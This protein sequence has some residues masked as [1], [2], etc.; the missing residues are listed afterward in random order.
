MSLLQRTLL[1]LLLTS[2]TG[3][4]DLVAQPIDDDARARLRDGLEKLEAQIEALP[5]SQPDQLQQVTDVEVFAKAVDWIDRHDEFFKPEFEKHAF[6]VLRQGQQRAAALKQGQ[7][8]WGSGSGRFILGY[9][10]AVDDSVQPYAI[11]LPKGFRPRATRP[12]PLHV[13]LHGRGGTLNEVSFIRQHEGKEVPDGQDWIQLDVFGRTN[14]A[15]RWAGETDV[16]EAMAD[17]QRRFRIDDRRI[18]LWGFSMGGAGAW[19]LGLHYPSLW[20][21]VGAGAGFVDFYRYQKKSEQLPEVQHRALRICDAVDYALN[22]HNVPFIT[23]GGEVDPQLAA[24][25]TMQ[26]L[27]KPL[28]APLEVLIGAKMGHKFD[29]ESKKKFMAFHAQHTKTGRPEAPGRREIRFVTLTPKYNRCEWL[30]LHEMEQMYEPATVESS[31]ENGV[32]KVTTTNVAALS[33]AR[34]IAAVVQLD[35]SSAIPLRSAGDSRLPEVSFVKAEDGWRALEGDALRAFVEN[36][37]RHKRKDLQ[38]PI[39]DAFMSPFVCVRGTGTPWSEPL[40]NWSDWTFERFEKEFDKWMRGR[41][42]TVNDTELTEEQIAER[43]LILFGDPGSNAILAKV[44]GELPV[45]WTRD[46]LTVGGQTYSTSDHAVVLIFPNPLN[47]ERYVVVNSGHTIHEKDFRSSNAWL[48]PRLG[49][50]SVL[51]FS[52]SGEGYN[53]EV[54]WSALF[55]SKW[56]LSEGK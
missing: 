32:L 16:L 1:I 39:D 49:D 27:A 44:V 38:G 48:F 26:E 18:T 36:R 45:E 21:S 54:A 56:R 42:P 23:Y 9:R 35:D 24:S 52:R 10:S 5:A 7:A 37:Q 33:I 8:R 3:P 41:V 28:D 40:K 17:V 11:S 29:D 34:N 22:L 50:I 2:C 15:Y 13:V 47:P 55:D 43:H 25:L 4:R 30:T 14:N 20:S 51:K 31:Y 12:W 53:E 46:S 19:H 6:D